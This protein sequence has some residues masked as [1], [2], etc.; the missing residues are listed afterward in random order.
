MG[1]IDLEDLY[2]YKISEKDKKI[3]ISLYGFMALLSLLFL[4]KMI[5]II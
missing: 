3:I 4:F 1:Y 5:N 2:G